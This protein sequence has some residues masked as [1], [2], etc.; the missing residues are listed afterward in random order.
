M[1]LNDLSRYGSDSDRSPFCYSTSVFV[2]HPGR[3]FCEPL[4]GTPLP[5]PINYGLF[6]SVT[7][8]DT[9]FILLQYM[10]ITKRHE[11]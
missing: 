7:H 1:Q 4:A 2:T 5:V 6:P 9:Y 10:Q 8:P 3:V 11:I